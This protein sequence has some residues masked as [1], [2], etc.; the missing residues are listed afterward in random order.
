[1]KSMLGYKAAILAACAGAVVATA[2]A[3]PAGGS[4]NAAMSVGV[5]EYSVINLAPAEAE[6]GVLNQQGHAAFAY[7]FG[8][9]VGYFDG[10]RV[11][12]A[13]PFRAEYK[14]VTALNEQGV[15]IVDTGYGDGAAYSWSLARGVRLL[16]DSGFARGINKRGQIVGHA[17]GIAQV[18]K[19]DGSQANL[20]PT[21]ANSEAYDINNHGL[22]AGQ[23]AGRA[24]AWNANGTPIQ[25]GLTSTYGS[26]GRFV[27]AQD[28]VAGTFSDDAGMGVFVWSRKNGLVRIGPFPRLVRL[29]GLN[30]HGQIAGDR[31]VAEAGLS[32]T[33][34]PFTWTAQRGLRLLPIGS[35]VHGRVDALNNNAEMVG[36]IQQ[37]PFQENSK[38][39]TYW[40]DISQPVDLNARL[41]R[42][43]KGLVLHAAIAINDAGAILA[44]SNAGLVMLRPGRTGSAAPV[45]GPLT[46]ADRYTDFNST[47]DLTVTFVDSNAA[48]TH[49]ASASVDDG[50]P[51]SAPSLREVRGT[52]D[53]SL[54][55]TFCRAGPANIVIRVTDRAG[56]ATEARHTVYVSDPS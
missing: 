7:A 5:H 15:A 50:C 19:P 13:G 27:N 6:F 14:R 38:R 34:A 42:A 25:I 43:P 52:G 33:F 22:S 49:A 24:T 36:F 44:N 39:A 32:V 29:M 8:T 55:H 18:W 3:G 31:Q 45:L 26:E 46:G 41:Y 28:Q 12:P 37:L 2:T 23:Y 54:R 10:R 48:E 40:N 47:L 16:A 20:G 9:G 56:N 17:G 30:D 35:G 21:N 51:H 4:Q 11:Y 53:V 1:M